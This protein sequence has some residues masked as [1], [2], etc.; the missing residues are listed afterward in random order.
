MNNRK[1]ITRRGFVMDR[2]FSTFCKEKN[3]D[4]DSIILTLEKAV[5]YQLIIRENDVELSIDENNI[6]SSSVEY[7]EFYLPTVPGEQLYSYIQK[8]NSLSA[9]D[10][11]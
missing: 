1:G 3:I 10:I 4:K 11:G 5:S 8:L 2:H 9:N 7:Y 6:N